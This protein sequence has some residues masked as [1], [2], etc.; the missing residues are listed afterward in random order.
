MKKIIV[1]AEK[2]RLYT[3]TGFVSV[4]LKRYGFPIKAQMQV[5]LAVEKAFMNIASYAYTPNTGQVTVKVDGDREPPNI[6]IQF[7]DSG[8]PFNPFSE[9]D[10][11]TTFSAE[12][13]EIDGLGI[14]LIKKN[15]DKVNYEYK[16]GKNIL[17]LQKSLLKKL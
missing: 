10:A 11:D 8:K 15:V 12:E 13:H 2:D 3:V 9:P 16:E 17:T 6:I 4:E 5:G 14:L 7:I 1:P